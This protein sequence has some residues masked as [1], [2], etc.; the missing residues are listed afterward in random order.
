MQEKNRFNLWNNIVG[1]AV[2]FI[3]LVSYL[4]T[5]EP[6]TS[7]WDCS[8]FIAT[9][10]KLEV[11]H[12]PGAPL[13]MMLAR[14]ASIF[15]P[16]AEAVPMMINA[17][18]CLASGFCILFLFWTITNLA[19]LITSSGGGEAMSL[20]RMVLILGAG[21]VGALS[22]AYTDTF[23]FSAVEGEVYAMSSMFTAL[24]VWLMLKWEENADRPTAMRW[25]ILIAYLM[26]L[27]IGV[28]ILNLLTIPA[29]VMIWFFRRYE[30]RTA[31]DYVLKMALALVVSMLILGAINGLI[32]P[33]T[34]ALGAA[35]DTFAVNSLG[36]PVNVGMVVFLLLVFTALALLVLYTHRRGYRVLNG[37]VLAVTVILIGFS[38][39]ASVTIRAT[40]NPPMNSN[41][42]STPHMLLSLLNRDQ[43]GNRPLLYGPY[44]SAKPLAMVAQNDDYASDDQY[45]PTGDYESKS[46]MWL[47]PETGKYEEREFFDGYKYPSSANRFM[48]RMWFYSRRD[49]YEADWIALK[50]GMPTVRCED[51]EAGVWYEHT[52]MEDVNY[53]LGYQ[54]GDMFW[55]YFMWNFVGR[56]DDEQL[57]ADPEN[58][59]YLH[60]GWISGIDFIDELFAGPQSALPSDV[61]DNP[62]H[63]TYFFLPLLLGLLGLIYQ[64]NT[65][66]RNFVVVML[67]FVMMGIALVVYFN[68]APNE[69]RERDYVYAGAFYAFSI[70]LGLGVMA[71]GDLLLSAAR[72]LRLDGRRGAMTVTVVAVVMGAGVPTVLAAENW[73][74]HD[75]SGRYM[76]RD[77]GRNYLNTVPKNGIIINFGDNDTFPLWYCQE[78]EG[79]RPD[80]RVMN[81][82]YLGGEWYID[83]MKLAANEADG[84]PFTILSTKYSF[85]NDWVVV[86]D[87]MDV[88]DTD[89]A[90]KLRSE[91]RR[92]ENSE[93]YSIRYTDSAGRQQVVTGYYGD[94]N[95]KITQAQATIEE[96]QPFIE[97]CVAEG[98]TSSD[99]FYDAY[100][101]YVMAFDL[102]DAIVGDE[103]FMADYDTMEKYWKLNDSIAGATLYLEDAIRLFIS[104]E[105]MTL[106][107]NDGRMRILAEGEVIPRD[108][109]ADDY[110]MVGRLKAKV[111][112]FFD[113]LD[114]DYI[115]NVKRYAIPV[116]KDKVIASGLVEESDRERIVDEVYIDLAGK[117]VLTKDHLMMLDLFAH[118]DWERPLSFTQSHLMRDY[119]IVDYARFDGYSYTFVPILTRYKSG[120]EVGYLDADKLYPIFMGESAECEPLY[121]GNLADEDV[122][123]DYFYRF[124]ASAARQREN[125]ARVATEYLRRGENEDVVR[126]EALL[127]RGLEVLPSQ[128]IGYTHSNTQP[129]IRGYYTVASYYLMLAT[130]ELVE[131]VDKFNAMLDMNVTVEHDGDDFLYFYNLSDAAAELQST[132]I[133]R[134]VDVSSV[135]ENLLLS[136]ELFARAEECY[137]KGDVL[138]AEYI[139]NRGEWVR[140]YLQFARYD[141][142]STIISEELY[143]AMLDIIETLDTSHILAGSFD[144]V[145]NGDTERPLVDAPLIFDELVVSYLNAVK[146]LTPSS[147]DD[148]QM[149]LMEGHICNLYEI[150]SALPP[151]RFLGGV[152][153]EAPYLADMER[154]LS[155]DAQYEILQIY[156]KLK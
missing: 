39:Y 11:G 95:D 22:Y 50:N 156:G 132:A 13:F 126:A 90:R 33:Y 137:R 145:A 109:R 31:W 3:A 68:T 142:F 4:M 18:N 74:D 62:A 8:E 152:D 96:Y 47:N 56:Q 115:L 76:A 148:P 139:K 78:V 135:D 66:W 7:L 147:I 43:Y 122:L 49:N 106:V 99:A 28:H 54:M 9:S 73:D 44:Y 40:A 119:G 141:S 32:I 92:I 146:R 108:E 117:S 42:P 144:W 101:R 125:F 121:F 12:P 5:M 138:A 102:F 111:D 154:F 72:A 51:D 15:A 130:D 17:M 112:N 140:Y 37:V 75:R 123:V 14:I 52:A 46:M 114:A 2:F 84:V 97:Q 34:V 105:P 81:S 155:G 83:E 57:Q 86:A 48:P 89:Q 53:F 136:D 129:Y 104:D 127:D 61:R 151:T 19:R 103:R 1:W 94:I 82:S 110:R 64:L 45:I 16:S 38:S 77:I 55:R 10:Y 69:P 98:D 131:A 88:L 71:I 29:L 65:D 124:N 41:N 128:K 24:V 67:L 25:I 80:V 116:D 23:W 21:A 59:I 87:V 120:S 143:N 100:A 6:T 113:G 26:G 93:V 134:G 63:N 150:Y 36:L 79:V 20:S 91:R 149:A 85:V 58:R 60:G 107:V 153:S 27:S 35:V 30:Y 118:F 70:W 133:H